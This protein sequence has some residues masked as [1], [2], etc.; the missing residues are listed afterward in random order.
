MADNKK[1]I[2]DAADAAF[3]SQNAGTSLQDLLKLLEQ[4]PNDTDVLYRIARSYY[5]LGMSSYQDKELQAKYYKE[6][7]DHAEK[8]VKT[9][10]E[11]GEA[12]KWA[13]ALLGRYSDHVPTK[14]KI[15]Q[16]FNIKNYFEKAASL[17]PKDPVPLHSLGM[18][19]MQVSSIGWVERNVAAL[20]FATPP[21][22]TYQNALEYFLKC[23][24][25]IKDLEKQTGFIM[26]NCTETGK[27]Y[28]Y[29]GDKAKA[30]EWYQKVVALKDKPHPVSAGSS[31]KYSEERLAALASSWW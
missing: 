21:S 19:C 4:H 14:E 16:A 11:S 27:C 7:W 25:I 5:D 1:T 28:E 31:I 20:L 9:S 15:A 23:H 18:W 12:N 13:G 6:G 2:L 8:A 30:K 29:M 24:E 26:L 3:E 22:S 17:D 10:P